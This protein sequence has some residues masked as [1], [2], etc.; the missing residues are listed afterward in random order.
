M[1]IIH[2]NTTMKNLLVYL[3]SFLLLLSC[4]P[5]DM[6]YFKEK[7]VEVDYQA[8]EVILTTDENIT[9]VSFDASETDIEKRDEYECIK[10]EF[11]FITKCDWFTITVDRSQ[12]RRV[13][14]VLQ[15]NV[16]DKDRK[17]VVYVQRFA[18]SDFATIVQKAKP[19]E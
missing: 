11:F 17:V 16:T 14:V 10:D 18:G 19:A 12:P 1:L 15:E 2:I 5:V 4:E 6:I 8:Q 9:G 3:L 13:S 7:Y